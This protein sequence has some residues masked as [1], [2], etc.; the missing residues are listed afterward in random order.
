MIIINIHKCGERP[1]SYVVTWFEM[2]KQD[3]KCMLKD[4]LQTSVDEIS[5]PAK[6]FE[7]MD[8]VAHKRMK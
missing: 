5:S 2:G 7:F 4:R 3:S 6:I 1:F 8:K